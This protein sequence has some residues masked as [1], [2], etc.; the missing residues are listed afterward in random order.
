MD[1][2]IK[3]FFNDEGW[4]LERAILER[5]TV[6]RAYEF[7]VSRQQRL[8]QQFEAWSG[9]KIS[10]AADYARHQQQLPVHEAHGLPKDLRHYLTGE[11]DLETRLSHVIMELLA[12]DR[13]RDF[14]CRFLRSEHY[15][16]HYPPMIR[17]KIAHAPANL[18]PPHQDIAYNRHLTDFV[19]I[20][21]PLTDIDEERGGVVVYEGSHVDGD[22]EHA[23][24]G[25]WANKALADLSRYPARHV[26]MNAG[27]AL[28]FPPTLLHES[29]PHRSPRIRYSIDFRV[30]R[31]AGDTS[32]SYYDPF[33]KVVTQV[34]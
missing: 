6:A 4:H 11:F 5:G 28:L 3:T 1:T 25:A 9:E 32:K 29:A 22:V 18:V 7:L 20:W 17:F 23:A 19:T 34:S 14:V 16:V 31:R 30:F 10:G 27:D 15:F 8:Q 33:A 12:T 26:V 13:C 2:P 21:V 24:S